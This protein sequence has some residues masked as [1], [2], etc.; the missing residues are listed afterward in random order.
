[1]QYNAYLVWNRAHALLACEEITEEHW[2]R[3]AGEVLDE[4]TVQDEVGMA[5]ADEL[6]SS[7]RRGPAPV[8]G[9]QAHQSKPTR[10]AIAA[11]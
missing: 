8:P 7:R 9:A 4:I 10:L 11:V 3:R 1:M 2:E 6:A 5:A